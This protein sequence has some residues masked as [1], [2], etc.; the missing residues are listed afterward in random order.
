[1]AKLTQKKKEEKKRKIYALKSCYIAHLFSQKSH[2][3]ALLPK[4]DT[5]LQDW[6]QS[7]IIQSF[8]RLFIPQPSHTNIIMYIVQLS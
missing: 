4:T 7:S 8:Y 5:Q 3:H 2:N 1:M 6:E